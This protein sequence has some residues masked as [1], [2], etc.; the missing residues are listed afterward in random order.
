MSLPF[1]V[2]SAYANGAQLRVVCLNE[3]LREGSIR[4]QSREV[5]VKET[6]LRIVLLICA[7]LAV[8]ASPAL[9]QEATIVGTV[10][11]PSGASVPHATI[12]ITNT[13]TNQTRQ[14]FTN[15][16]GQYLAPSLQIGRY[17]VV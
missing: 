13:D 11:D 9:A 12:A 10:T 1:H 8:S 17:K 15:D 2:D 16:A 4:I 5:S 3:Q 7:L 6:S 14:V